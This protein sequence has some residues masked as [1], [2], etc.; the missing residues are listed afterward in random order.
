[1]TRRAFHLNGK[2]GFTLV[3]SLVGI[4]LVAIMFIS[5]MGVFEIAVTIVNHAA[6]RIVAV[7]LIQQR[8]ENEIAAA[9]SNPAANLGRYNVNDPFVSVVDNVTYTITPATPAPNPVTITTMGVAP[10]AARYETIGFTVQWN[11]NGVSQ[12]E[13]LAVQVADHT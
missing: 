12:T 1:M 13:K 2:R 8:L 3:E 5:I 9:V 4:S 10:N 7:N 6:H 11:E